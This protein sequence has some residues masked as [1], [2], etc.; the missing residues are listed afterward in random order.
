MTS[1]IENRVSQGGLNFGFSWFYITNLKNVTESIIK[2]ICLQQL[3][4][5]KITIFSFIFIEEKKS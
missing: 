5:S 1:H 4:F 2:K 3:K